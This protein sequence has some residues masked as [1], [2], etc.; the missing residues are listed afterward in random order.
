MSKLIETLMKLNEIYSE[1]ESA[2]YCLNLC[3]NTMNDAERALQ[4]DPKSE[5]LK[6][7]YES[8]KSGKDK[9]TQKL[10]TLEKQFD[11]LLNQAKADPEFEAELKTSNIIPEALKEALTATESESDSAQGYEIPE[12]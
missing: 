4:K 1:I 6:K 7:I 2:Y 3:E 11:S 8:A 9:F 12:E 10:E 5:E